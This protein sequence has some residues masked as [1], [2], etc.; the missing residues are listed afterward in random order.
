M[1]AL[2]VLVTAV[3]TFWCEKIEIRPQF[4]ISWATLV[5]ESHMAMSNSGTNM[6]FSHAAGTQRGIGSHRVKALSVLVTA[7]CALCTRF[8]KTREWRK[9]LWAMLV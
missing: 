1:K 9:L 7:V 5:W 2:S 8:A 3:C 4:L 6:H